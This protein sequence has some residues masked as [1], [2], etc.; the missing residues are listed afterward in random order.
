A[1]LPLLLLHGSFYPLPTSFFEGDPETWGENPVGNGPF[2]MSAPW[3][4]DVQ[5]ATEAF[6][7][8]KGATP[9]FDKLTFKIYSEIDTAYNDLRAGALD[10]M[11]TVPPAELA[12][13]Q[14][15]FAGRFV[16]QSNTVL[17][18]LGFPI[19]LELVA[20]WNS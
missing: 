16:S 7:D 4:H 1:Q 19:D 8:Y 15:E 5:I 3:E 13:Y 11:D 9:S 17:Q 6:A 18:Y 2:Q 20:E 12:N 10:I 14:E